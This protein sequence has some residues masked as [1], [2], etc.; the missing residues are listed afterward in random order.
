MSPM[1]AE[2][3]KGPTSAIV[4][5]DSKKTKGPTSSNVSYGS[6]KTKGPTSACKFIIK[7]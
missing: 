2:K 6:K 3:I 5:Y 1:A 7:T 4:S